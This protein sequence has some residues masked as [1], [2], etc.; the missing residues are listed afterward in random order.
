MAVFSDTGRDW[1]RRIVIGS[2]G[3]QTVHEAHLR[4]SEAVKQPLRQ[5]GIEEQAEV[6]QPRPRRLPLL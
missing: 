6:A 1:W 5:G 2:N 3:G 4:L